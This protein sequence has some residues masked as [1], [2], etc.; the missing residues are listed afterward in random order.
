[1]QPLS[2]WVPSNRYH[3]I[4]CVH[5]LHYVGDKLAIIKTALQSLDDDGLFIA[6]ADLA[7]VK[8]K[9]D[10]SNQCLKHFF[11]ENNIDYNVRQKIIRC[12]GPRSISIPFNYLGTDDKA[13]PNYTGQEVVDSYYEIK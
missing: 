4:T 13:G 8:V 5:G 6:N 10:R 1:M 2:S 12:E 11:N 3:L 9:G 7:N